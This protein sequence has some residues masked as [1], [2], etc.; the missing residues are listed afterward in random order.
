MRSFASLLIGLA[1]LATS[2][3]TRAD[4]AAPAATAADAVHFSYE[5]DEG[6]PSQSDFTA[7]LRSRGAAF[8]VDDAAPRA[9]EVAMNRDPE[10]PTRWTGNMRVSEGGDSTAATR[11]TSATSCSEL[12]RSLAIFTSLA[13]TPSAPP[14]KTLTA[15]HVADPVDDPPEPPPRDL[16]HRQRFSLDPH[17]TDFFS[18]GNDPGF[19]GGGLTARYFPSE[20]WALRLDGDVVDSSGW[21]YGVPLASADTNVPVT[22]PMPANQVR[23]RT[24]LSGE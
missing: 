9:L 7:L 6:C 4:D 24:M 16:L 17:F 22:F 11:T 13:L 5:V 8:T 15:H 21:P 14:P 10:T 19:V 12:A 18:S 2:S 23:A 1:L 20:R 3:I